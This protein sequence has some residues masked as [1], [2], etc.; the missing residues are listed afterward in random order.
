MT[1]KQLLIVRLLLLVGAALW[2]SACTPEAP[3]G[4]IVATSAPDAASYE[5]DT[6]AGL[7]LF[8]E[9]CLECHSATLPRAFVGPTLYQAGQRLTADYIRASVIAPHEVVSAEY[10]GTTPMPTNLA[11]QLS[12]QDLANIVAYLLASGP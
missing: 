4:D 8:N 2:L 11:E 12:E 10:A 5:G 9:Y 6:E 1:T 7:L 3:A